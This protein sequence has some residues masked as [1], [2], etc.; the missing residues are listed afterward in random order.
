MAKD[1]R[2][3][4]IADFKNKKIRVLTNYGVLTEGFDYEELDLIIS[5]RPTKSSL[6]LTQILGRGTRWPKHIQPHKIL[7]FVEIVDLHSDETATAASI[8]GFKQDFDCE[9]VDFLHCIRVAKD[10]EKQKD[11]FSPWSAKSFTRMIEDFEK[12]KPVFG[13]GATNGKEWCF[14]N[15]YRYTITSGNNLMLKHREKTV[16]PYTQVETTKNFIVRV[17]ESSLGGFSGTI[18]ERHQD[19][20]ETKL[21]FF[22]G[23]TRIAVIKR[24]EEA[25]L[26]AYP[27]WDRL[28]N[29]NAGWRQKAKGEPCSDKQWALIQKMKLNRGRKR[30][31][32]TKAD[33]MEMLDRHFNR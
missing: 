7:D 22:E 30:E 32:I 11:Y 20:S 26:K 13:P 19:R 28:L 17:R 6:L 5:A 29:I 2:K 21:Y 14:E 24:L 9:G 33:A 10:M 12:A 16:D 23:D 18:S 8:F 15:R 3:Q 4:Y 27:A 31:S 25:I 1:D